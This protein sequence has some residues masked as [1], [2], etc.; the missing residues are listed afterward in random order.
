VRRSYHAADLYIERL[1][2]KGFKVAVVEQVEDPNL[3]KG[4]VKRE[5]I[6]LITPGTVIDESSLDAKTNNFIGALDIGRDS[7]ILAYSDLST[8]ITAIVTT[9]RDL[10]IVTSEIMNLEIRE[11]VIPSDF[12]LRQLRVCLEERTITLSVCDQTELPT[13]YR[14]LVQ[15]IYDKE[16]LASFARLINYLIKTQKRELM[17]LQK[18]EVF[19]SAKYLNLDNNSIRNLELIETYRNQ[20]KKGSLFWLLDRSETAMGSRLL[21]QS[22]LRPLVDKQKIIRRYRMVEALNDNFIIREEITDKLKEVYDLERI[23]GRVSFGNANAKDLVNLKRSLRAAPVIK[24]RLESIKDDLTDGLLSDIGD[25]TDLCDLIEKAIV[26]NP[27]LGIKDGGIIRSGYSPELDEVRNHA[28]SGKDW[29][30][31]FEA[32]ERDRTG[33]K[34]LK[35]GYN[36]VF[37]YYIEIS[38]GQ[39][40]QVTSDFGYERKQTLVNSERFVTAEL[41]RMEAMI[42][43]SEER[44]IELE[45]ALFA[46]IRDEVFKQIDEIQRLARALALVDMLIAFSIVSMDNRYVKPNITEERVIDIYGG[47]HPVVEKLLTEGSFV[48]ND[49]HLGLNT[50]ILLI[51][52]RTCRGNRLICASWPSLSS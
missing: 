41:K 31:K 40:E 27:P 13:I 7:Y 44:S 45:Y 21:R 22:I 5:V 18:V 23:I 1:I 47:R 29:I 20:A 4:L 52:V 51:P 37:G 3:A 14:S 35:I 9:P 33:I 34:K 42:L 48:E 36:R 6:R 8:G 10:E 43:G 11:L 38:R 19:E 25:F 17:H 39:L 30:Q 12:N 26:D 28:H 50:D 2:T 24:W 46:A 32:D 16:L 15:E 49:I